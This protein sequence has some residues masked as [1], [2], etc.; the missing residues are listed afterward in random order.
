MPVDNVHAATATVATAREPMIAFLGRFLAFGAI[1]GLVAASAAHLSATAAIPVWAMFVGWVA[2]FT[3]GHSGRDGVINYLC[4]AA[5]IAL[6]LGATAALG[7]LGPVL[8]GFALPVVVFMVAVLVVSFRA[9]PALNNIPSYFLGLISVFAAHAP[10]TLEAFAELGGASALGSFSAWL[11]AT[12]QAGLA[13][14]VPS[15]RT[16]HP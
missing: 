5:G 9:L 12:A 16:C 3:R 1:A 8:G 7:L 2:Y 13:R 6:G 10:P 4:V 15:P 14:R 11:A